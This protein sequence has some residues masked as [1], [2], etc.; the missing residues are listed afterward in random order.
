MG[1]FADGREIAFQDVPA[2]KKQKGEEIV[3]LVKDGS[4]EALRKLAEVLRG[5]AEDEVI[6]GDYPM[7]YVGPLTCSIAD[8]VRKGEA[9][10]K[11]IKEQHPEL[12]ESVEKD[13]R[14]A[15]SAWEMME[16]E[17]GPDFAQKIEN[18]AGKGSP[19]G[20]E[21]LLPYGIYTFCND[22]LRFDRYFESGGLSGYI[23]SES[24][25]FSTKDEGGF[26]LQRA[27][28]LSHF[29]NDGLVQHELQHLFDNLIFSSRPYDSRVVDSEYRAFAAGIAFSENP[30]SYFHP[31]EF[32]VE[33]SRHLPW[34]SRYCRA[35]RLVHRGMS[36]ACKGGKDPAVLRRTAHD[37]LNGSYKKAVG[38]TYD[39]I[40]EPFQR[41]P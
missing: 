36:E 4:S 25:F 6:K 21:P 16:Q 28:I 37:L 26:T 23:L 31:L 13:R 7:G 27:M 35:I 1:I 10:E 3:R 30:I 19:H 12:W 11:I 34:K 14:E 2:E 22:L 29:I 33:N 18:A 9:V 38:L 40:L 32:A 17:H 8:V 15:K 39:E 5:I 20:Y 41:Q 24:V